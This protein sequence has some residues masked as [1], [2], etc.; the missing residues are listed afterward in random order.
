MI[1]RNGALADFISAGARVLEA[2]CGP[3]IGMGQAPATG[4][5]SLRTFNRNFPGRSGTRDDRVYLCSPET[6]AAA[7]ITGV[8]TDP[9]TL[10]AATRATIPDQYVVDD[11]MIVPPLAEPERVEV[12]RGPNIRPIPLAPPLGEEIAGEV[13]IKLGDNISTDH[14]SPA[15]AAILPLRSNLPAIAEYTFTRVDSEFPKRAKERGGGFIVGGNNY[16]QGSAREHAALAPRY[17]GVQA[18]LAQSFARIHHINLVNFGVLP[19][20]FVDV[21]DYARLAQGDRLRLS[22]VRAALR[23][24]SVLEIENVTQGWKFPVRHQLTARQV[25]I[26]IAGGLLGFIRSGPG[27]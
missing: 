18:V 12:I 11:N 7:A 5:V 23:A 26:M 9:R 22:D 17:L 8:I 21:A 10:G 13:L 27:K 20:T 6:A 15:G 3:C 24:G 2:A 1:A 14:I 16:G 19:L 25:E 4:A